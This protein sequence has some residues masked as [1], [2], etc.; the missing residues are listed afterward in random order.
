MVNGTVGTVCPYNSTTW[1]RCVNGGTTYGAAAMYVGT[2]IVDCPTAQTSAQDVL[3]WGAQCETGTVTSYVATTSASATRAVETHKFPALPNTMNS[4][5]AAVSYI[6]QPYI[7]YSGNW[8]PSVVHGAN[9][10]FIYGEGSNV[11][12]Y[13]GTT[14]LARSIT[15]DG[16]AKRI[17]SWWNATDG[18]MQI[19]NDTDS[20]CSAVTAYDK[21]MPVGGGALLD[22]CSAV[23]IGTFAGKAACTDLMIDYTPSRCQ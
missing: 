23:Q 5:C 14:A 21:T 22:F 3:V 13:D 1:T 16:G 9:A 7:T 10:A 12:M 2:D 8:G 18:G 20:S 17:R 6:P 11:K 15:Q 4:G 19:C